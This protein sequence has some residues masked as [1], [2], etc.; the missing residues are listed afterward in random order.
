MAEEYDTVYNKSL[1]EG[2]IS[3]MELPGTVM[4]YQIEAKEMHIPLKEGACVYWKFRA[5]SLGELG[6]K[7]GKSKGSTGLAKHRK[8]WGN[9]LANPIPRV[10]A[11]EKD[12]GDMVT[13]LNGQMMPDL[14]TCSKF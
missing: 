1:V 7:R 3:Q 10:Y 12:G 6:Q 13:G 4:V 2:E 8:T 9:F 11:W 14:Y 5:F